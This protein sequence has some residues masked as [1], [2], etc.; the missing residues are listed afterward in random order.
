MEWIYDFVHEAVFYEVYEDRPEQYN[1]VK[2]RDFAEIVAEVTEYII[3]EYGHID[4]PDWR[5]EESAHL[6]IL[7]YMGTYII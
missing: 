3:D 4:D 7:D 1:W 6:A 2:D 5:D